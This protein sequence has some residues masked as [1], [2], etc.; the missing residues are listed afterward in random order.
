MLFFN[1]NTYYV[2]LSRFIDYTKQIESN[3]IREDRYFKRDMLI[4][5]L[6]RFYIFEKNSLVSVSIDLRTHKSFQL[7][8]LTIMVETTICIISLTIGVIPFTGMLLLLIN[9]IKLHRYYSIS[10]H[11]SIFETHDV[12]G[13]KKKVTYNV[14]QR[15]FQFQRKSNY[16]LSFLGK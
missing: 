1:E 15:S 12:N 6:I 3:C 7:L 16:L 8:S 2:A 9:D 10:N 5:V 14:R 4:I 11:L 13:R